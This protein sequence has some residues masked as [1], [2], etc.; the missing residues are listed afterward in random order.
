MIDID[1]CKAAFASSTL[2]QKEFY[3]PGTTIKPEMLCA[4][5]AL[6][7]YAGVAPALIGKFSKNWDTFM[8][9]VQPVLGVEYGI[10]RD[11]SWKIPSIFDGADNEWRAVE[12][13]LGEFETYNMGMLHME[14]IMEDRSRF[15]RKG[16]LGMAYGVADLSTIMFSH[17]ALQFVKWD[18][19]FWVEEEAP[20]SKIIATPAKSKYLPPPKFDTVKIAELGDVLAVAQ[21]ALGTEKIPAPHEFSPNPHIISDLVPPELQMVKVAT[22]EDVA[23]TV[24]AQGLS[25]PSWSLD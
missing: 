3:Q 2:C 22:W 14:A 16:D 21:K 25:L 7:S 24:P 23:S 10:P 19:M 9:F 20:K 13:V 17:N 8:R 18:K 1:K 15:P 6:A 4:V 12:A 5:S 11:V